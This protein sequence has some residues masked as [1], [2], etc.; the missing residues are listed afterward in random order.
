MNSGHSCSRRVASDGFGSHCAVGHARS[1]H[2]LS[3]IV[4]QP[5]AVSFG[6]KCRR[7]I[8]RLTVIQISG[9]PTKKSSR[10]SSIRLV[11]KTA[12]GS[13]CQKN[14]VLL[15]VGEDARGLPAIV[16]SSLQPLTPSNLTSPLPAKS[17]NRL[18]RP[19]VDS[20]TYRYL[21]IQH[22]DPTKG[23]KDG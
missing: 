2:L 6:S 14:V 3:V 10:Q 5:L 19:Y 13:F 4:A 15:E 12:S 20:Y 8:A 11:A 1:S 23:V 17:R 16:R 21:V 22:F 18:T 9:K 7:L